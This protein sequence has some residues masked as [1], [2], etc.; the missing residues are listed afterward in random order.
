M[1]NKQNRRNAVGFATRSPL[2]HPKIWIG[3]QNRPW[4]NAPAPGLTRGKYHFISDYGR[5]KP[6][7]NLKTT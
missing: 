7:S 4:I 1:L 2:P 6:L 3:D 5:V